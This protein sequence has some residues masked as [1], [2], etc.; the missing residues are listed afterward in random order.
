MQS[1]SSLAPA[2]KKGDLALARVE[3]LNQEG[4]G[5]AR[6]Q[7]KATFIEGA[8]PGESVRFRV[9]QC[10]KSYDLGKVT[11]LLE[12]SP[13]RVTPRCS[14]FGVCG[15]CSLQHLQSEAQLAAKEKIL[16]DTLRRIGKVEPER[17][18]EPLTGPHWGYRRKARLGVRV[19]EKKGG[20]IVGFREKARSF[21]TPLASCE[22]MDPRVSAL[23]PAIRQLITSLSCPDRIPQIE[24]AAGDQTVSLVFRHLVPVTTGDDQLL[25]GFAR[26]HNV[27]VFRQPGK[28]DSL[29]PVWPETPDVLHY[30]I[31]EFNIELEFAPTDFVQ[32]NSELNRMMVR[33]ALTLLNPQSGDRILDL[34]CGLGNFTL[35]LA[36]RAGQVLG[37]EADQALVDKARHNAAH[38]G[39]R[40]VEFRMANLYD[41]DRPEPWGSQH[42]DKWLLD[43]PRTGAVEVVKRMPASGAPHR[44]VYISCNPGTLARDSEVLVHV[45]GYR[46]K[47]AGA[48]DMFPQTSHVEALALFER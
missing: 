26:A 8:L 42:F 5:V 19:V 37:V 35:P 11:D 2:L 18:L 13:D 41:Q 4:H 31:P 22:V 47:A 14:Y 29:V 34:F 1:P 40:N 28:P 39:L 6:V 16:R 24:V 7:G 17:W 12:V 27:Q 30:G 21:I 46:L 32:V 33:R 44:L 20:V 3:S 48:L 23:L 43:P 15:G 36:R 25:A 38:N 10:R 45:K 9:I